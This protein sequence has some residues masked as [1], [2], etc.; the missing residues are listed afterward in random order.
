MLTLGGEVANFDGDV[1]G[2]CEE[3]VVVDTFGLVSV[4]LFGLVSLPL[5]ISKTC[6][7]LNGISLIPYSG[8]GVLVL[9]LVPSLC[10][11]LCL[12][13]LSGTSDGNLTGLLLLK[14]ALLLILSSSESDNDSGDSDIGGG[15]MAMEEIEE[16][17]FDDD[18]IIE[19]GRE[20]R[21]SVGGG[22]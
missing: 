16:D 9:V 11:S 2:D 18:F 12:P 21:G 3:E 1:E 19:I 10:A 5:S 13:G 14:S 20:G 4:I 6:L 7:A 17:L 8:L 22:A 15:A